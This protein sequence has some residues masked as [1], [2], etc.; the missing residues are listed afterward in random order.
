ML[1]VIAFF[2]IVHK[3]CWPWYQDTRSSA[4]ASHGLECGLEG[5]RFLSS[6]SPCPYALWRC[7]LFPVRH[8]LLKLIIIA[9]VIITIFTVLLLVLVLLRRLLRVP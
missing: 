1:V 5:N 7:Y 6:G 3:E 8:K 9:V 4:Q 2:G